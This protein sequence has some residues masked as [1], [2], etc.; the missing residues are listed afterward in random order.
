MV[1]GVEVS[2]VVSHSDFSYVY[3]PSEQKLMY[4]LRYRSFDDWK[5]VPVE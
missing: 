4:K 2:P 3:H 1:V 5:D